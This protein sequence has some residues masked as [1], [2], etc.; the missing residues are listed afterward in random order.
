VDRP[1]KTYQAVYEALF[2]ADL[3]PVIDLLSGENP[4]W[5]FEEIMSLERELGVRSTFFFLTA[6]RVFER[7]LRE[8]FSRRN[9]IEHLGRYDIEDPEMVDV[10][11][12]LNYG[13]WEVGLHSSY[14]SFDNRDRL[15]YEK[16]RIES[17][18]GK[19][20]TGCRQHYLNLEEPATWRHQSSLGLSYDASLGSAEEVGF[21][22]GYDVKKPLDN[23]FVVFPLTA[24]E[25]ALPSPSLSPDH[26][27]DT[28]QSL[29]VEAKENSGV[30]T[31]LWHPRYFSETE[32][33]GYKQ[34]YR[35][36]VIE[37]ISMGAW[38][39]S[40]EQYYNGRFT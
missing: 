25:V 11:E 1:Y 29:L 10:I 2:T 38:V 17:V 15:N 26:A 8:W 27:W 31:V 5:Q 9:I 3:S 28:C 35:K 12:S 40:L 33:P 34:L 39:G 4:Y 7:P 19:T 14:H 16:R 21:H 24:M 6:E 30:M 13:G 22:H 37:A 36:L 32:F 20:I 23:E 18:L